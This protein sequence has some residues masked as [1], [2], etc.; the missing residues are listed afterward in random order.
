[1]VAAKEKPPAGEV[2]GGSCFSDTHTKL[3]CVSSMLVTSLVHP[4]FH[5]DGFGIIAQDV[6]QGGYGNEAEDCS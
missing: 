4:V 5:L 3:E 2:A 1:M 6:E